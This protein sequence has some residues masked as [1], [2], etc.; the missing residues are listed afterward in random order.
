MIVGREA[1][2]R[3]KLVRIV[4]SVG[5]IA[6]GGKLERVLGIKSNL[7]SLELAELN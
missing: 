1:G 3:R 6:G 5:G 2:G 7:V 4:D